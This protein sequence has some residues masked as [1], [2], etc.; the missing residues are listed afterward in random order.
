MIRIPGLV[1]ATAWLVAAMATISV[2]AGAGPQGAGP[3]G[4]IKGRVTLSGKLPGN[5]VIRMGKDP[6]C[7]SLNRGKQVVQEVV[8]AT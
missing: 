7:A 2:I 6:M 3:R 8:V 4:T 5:P 1:G